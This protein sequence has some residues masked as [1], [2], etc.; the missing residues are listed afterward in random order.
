MTHIQ[1]YQIVSKAFTVLDI[2]SE[3]S[4]TLEATEKS[5]NIPELLTEA[6]VLDPLCLVRSDQKIIG[7]LTMEDDFSIAQNAG[8]LANP[9]ILEQIVPAS[10]P[11]LELLPLFN[12]H[13]FFFVLAGNRITHLVSFIHI[14]KLPMK[15]CLFSLFMELESVMIK[16]LTENSNAELYISYLSE[17]RVNKARELCKLKNKMETPESLLICTTFIDK[18]NIFQSD[19]VLS[20]YLPFRDKK[21]SDRFFGD[22]EKIRNQ[23]AH[24]DSILS[25]IN[26]PPEIQKFVTKLNE[27]IASL[28]WPEVE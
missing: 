13:F 3:I 28:C 9:I 24:G 14:D 6:D 12:D 17:T 2:A 25:I 22:L 23:I 7:Y 26:T 10:T 20:R 4:L 1:P 16:R 5:Q 15:L 27:T 11:L 18:V 21:E 19:K 8:E